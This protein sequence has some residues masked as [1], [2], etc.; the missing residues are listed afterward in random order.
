MVRVFGS[1][2][3]FS[4]SYSPGGIEVFSAVPFQ[5]VITERILLSFDALREKLGSYDN[6]NFCVE[7]K[8]GARAAPVTTSQSRSVVMKTRSHERTPHFKKNCILRPCTS[9]NYIRQAQ[10]KYLHGSKERLIRPLNSKMHLLKP[11]I[12]DL[13][14]NVCI[15]QQLLKPSKNSATKV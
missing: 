12:C 14:S 8:S 2:D 1:S 9:N 10:P 3:V 6:N 5:L 4:F 7:C 11:L 15:N 13:R